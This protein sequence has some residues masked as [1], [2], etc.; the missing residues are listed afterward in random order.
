MNDLDNQIRRAFDELV[1]AAPP[2]PSAPSP[3]VRF[4][5]DR[6][7]RSTRLLAVAASVLVVAALGMVAYTQR[8]GPAPTISTSDQPSSSEIATTAPSA[9]T[10]PT[11]ENSE[12]ILIREETGGSPDPVTSTE[13]IASVEPVDSNPPVTAL[14]P[15]P[16][17]EYQVVP[18]PTFPEATEPIPALGRDYDGVHFAYLHEGPMPDGPLQLRFDVV[19]AYSG[20]ACIDRFGDDSPDVCTPFGTDVTGRVDQL[21]LAVTD[22]PISVRNVASDANYR[23]SGTEL[24]ALVNGS[25]ASPS[26]PD[27][28]MFSS[29]YG[30]L[31]TFD[32]GTLTG[33]DQPGAPQPG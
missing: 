17:G 20:Q 1:D 33:I 12:P 8:N 31:L 10:T 27:G 28:F 29:G 3:I 7:P 25:T 19:Q 11:A 32:N 16:S 15:S 4:T 21:D 6:E 30:F 23:I 5:S 9:A 24:I 2:P 14:E 13:S 22:I 26:A 18:S